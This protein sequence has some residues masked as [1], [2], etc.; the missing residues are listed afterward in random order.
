MCFAW[1]SPVIRFIYISLKDLR[2][3]PPK[4]RSCVFLSACQ[5]PSSF[6]LSSSFL[7]SSR[8]ARSHVQSLWTSGRNDLIRKTQ[9]N[10]TTP[11]PFILPGNRLFTAAGKIIT[12][13]QV[14]IPQPL[15]KLSKCRMLCYAGKHHSAA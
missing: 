9:N 5:M 1:N 12:V 8:S 4:Q 11:G 13:F 7:C 3:S 6:S 2:F 10:Q 14:Q 15:A